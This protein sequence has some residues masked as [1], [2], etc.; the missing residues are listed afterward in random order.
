MTFHGRQASTQSHAGNSFC[1][2]E[3][4]VSAVNDALR[5][6]YIQRPPGGGHMWLPSFTR[7]CAILGP[8]AHMIPVITSDHH[9]HIP[10]HHRSVSLQFVL[11]YQRCDHVKNQM[12]QN[13]TGLLPSSK[14][15]I[16]KPQP[17]KHGPLFVQD[18][19]KRQTSHD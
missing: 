12:P 10:R 18:T 8:S 4:T 13:T 7:L 19:T 2:L 5:K 16:C 9:Q 11:H 3:T 17:A 15:Q 6:I 1:A 14:T